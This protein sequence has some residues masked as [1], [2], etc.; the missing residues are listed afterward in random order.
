MYYHFCPFHGLFRWMDIIKKDIEENSK[1]IAQKGAMPSSMKKTILSML[2]PRAETR[3]PI[4][5]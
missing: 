2:V 3:V 5:C 4:K 1:K